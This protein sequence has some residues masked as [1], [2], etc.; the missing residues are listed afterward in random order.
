L[1]QIKFTKSELRNQ[2]LKLLQLEKYLPTLQLK[3]AMLQLE[4]N[5]CSI[6]LENAK[7]KLITIK[8]EVENSSS[9]LSEKVEF[10]ALA[11]CEIENIK[12]DY[13]N[14]AG[15]EIP[16]FKDII[17]KDSSYFTFDTPVWADAF[18]E[19]IKALFREREIVKVINEKKRALA[20]DLRE[21]SIR[22]NLFEKILI[23]RTK[24][25]IR[26][27]KIFL[28]DQLLAEIAQAKVAKSKLEAKK[29]AVV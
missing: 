17:F 11:Q 6:E 19:K 7:T 15:V 27:I 22:V 21:V 18:L 23:P 4:V 26:K 5:Q 20:K 24:E 13:E 9:L 1:T 2:Q 16:I 8:N 25:Y 10:N 14:I 28:G 3:K 29:G 12:K